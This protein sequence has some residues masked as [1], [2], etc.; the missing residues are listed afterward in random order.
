MSQVIHYFV[1]IFIVFICA[2]IRNV[3]FYETPFQ[4]SPVSIWNESTTEET[5]R[6]GF[7]AGD[8]R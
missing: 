7:S 3:L 6:E 5:T 2:E 1:L 8:I 4:S